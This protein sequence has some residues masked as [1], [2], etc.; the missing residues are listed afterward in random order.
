[1]K[2]LERNIN[3]QLKV[4]LFFISVLKFIINNI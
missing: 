1:M 4:H 3:K 2:K